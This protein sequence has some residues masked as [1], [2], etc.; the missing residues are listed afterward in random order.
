MKSI[1]LFL[2]L[3]FILALSSCNS[4]NRT[5]SAAAKPANGQKDW[6]AGHENDASRFA[7]M[8]PVSQDHPFIIASYEELIT[9]LT[10]GTGVVVFGFTACPRCR[11]AFPV[12]EQA[13]KEMEMTQ[14]AGFRGK[15]VFYDIYDDRE[16]NNERY[17]TIVDY[18]KDFLPKDERG[19]PR[20]YS[21]DVYFLAS[22]KIVGN[23]LDTVPSLKNP[24]DPLN[25][26][27]KEELLLIYKDLLEKVEDCGC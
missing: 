2:C 18:L 26:E 23:H 24:R 5:G 15:I 21:P 17:L 13:F 4:G 16:E 6:F 12:L 7:E 8:Y 19:N 20:I 3:S 10:Y 25:V 9:H 1:A 14:Y 27:Q 11:N 22:G